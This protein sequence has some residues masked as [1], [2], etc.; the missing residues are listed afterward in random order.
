MLPQTQYAVSF[1]RQTIETLEIQK[2]KNKKQKAYSLDV[3]EA[4][5]WARIYSQLDARKINAHIIQKKMRK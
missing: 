1:C 2:K 5:K 3:I 4:L